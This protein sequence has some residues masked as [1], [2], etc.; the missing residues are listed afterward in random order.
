M[1]IPS[2]LEASLIDAERIAD[3]VASLAEVHLIPTGH[4]SFA[5]AQA[6]PPHTQVYGGAGRAYPVGTE[7]VHDLSRS[8]LR[9]AHTR[10]S[11]RNVTGRLIVDALGHAAAAGLTA[12]QQDAS[13]R[14]SGRVRTII[15]EGQRAFVD[16]DGGGFATVVAERTV[17]GVGLDRVLSPGMPVAGALDLCSR[18]LDV[19]GSLGAVGIDE[20]TAGSVVLARVAATTVD[21]AAL[22]LAPGVRVAVHRAA[23]T[24]NDLD[25]VDGLLT[26]G[27]VVRARVLSAS[28]WALAMFDV[29]DDEPVLP[30]VA[31][32]PGGPSWLVEEERGVGEVQGVRE[33]RGLDGERRRAPEAPT[34]PA[35]SSAPV[36]GRPVPTPG[37]LPRRGVATQGGPSMQGGPSSTDAD[38]IQT[39]TAGEPVG[40]VRS[41]SLTIQSLQAQ[42]ARLTAQVSGGQRTEAAHREELTAL[43]A[44]C[45]RLEEQLDAARIALERT[46]AKYRNADRARQVLKRR[47]LPQESRVEGLWFTDPEEQFRA[48]MLW[49]WTRRIQPSEKAARPLRHVSFGESFLESV[50]HLQGIDRSKIVA[51][52]VEVATGLDVELPGRE[53]H[54]LRTSE[55]GD[56]PQRRRADGACAW[57]V[58][59]QAR[60]AG[61]RRLHYWRLPDGSI[62]FTSVHHHDQMAA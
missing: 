18:V 34:A 23:I 45:A 60:S 4:A 2:G 15:C 55:A 3:D 28:P 53:L 24:E 20:Y 49:E 25:Q 26:V 21:E 35:E 42:V 38:P 61:A 5:F 27:E 16:L 56:S 31:L 46:K 59:L 12:H 62:E 17:A 6:M 47:Q 43:K 10:T 52:L 44:D 32:L 36:V 9:F 19:T 39:T 30:A 33:D 8:P 11:G 1:S 7:W 22:E 13:R 48:E 57:R 29:D 51:V 54:P 37:S 50:A 41:M 14:V 58:S 40:V